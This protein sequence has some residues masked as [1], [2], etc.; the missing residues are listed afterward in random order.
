MTTTYHIRSKATAILATIFLLPALVFFIIWLSVGLQGSGLNE[1]EKLS[2]YLGYFP[3]FMHNF[4]MIHIISV[5]CCLIAIVLAAKS[6]RK[7]L[8]SVRVL[9]LLTVLAAFLIL[10]FDIYQM[11]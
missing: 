2:A 4:K 11:V 6:F 1:E 3:G 8:L 7:R 9:M 5:V 10:L